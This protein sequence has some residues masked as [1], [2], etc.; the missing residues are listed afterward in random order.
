MKDKRIFMNSFTRI[1]VYAWQGLGGK[2]FKL[3]YGLF[4]E[5]IIGLGL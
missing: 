2:P 4:I 3:F 5:L 1:R